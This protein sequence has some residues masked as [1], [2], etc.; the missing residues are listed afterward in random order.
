LFE[1]ISNAQMKRAQN[2]SFEKVK[3]IFLEEKARCQAAVDGTKT[4]LMLELFPGKELLDHLAKWL[5]LASADI[6]LRKLTREFKS[7]DFALTNQLRSTL[8]KSLRLGGISK[9]TSPA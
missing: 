9:P 2:V 6:L 4:E 1:Q 7:Q 3:A 5:G 8:Q